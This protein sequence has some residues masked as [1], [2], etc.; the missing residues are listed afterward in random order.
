MYNLIEFFFDII[1]LGFFIATANMLAGKSWKHIDMKVLLGFILVNDIYWAFFDLNGSALMIATTYVIKNVLIVITISQV[2]KLDVLWSASLALI[3]ALLPSPL[4]LF[5]QM[6]MER[7]PYIL[8]HKDL[9]TLT[10]GI[11]V[12][13]GLMLTIVIFKRLLTPRIQKK[14]VKGIYKMR[15]ILS[16][17]LLLIS[18]SVFQS[19]LTVSDITIIDIV[20]NT[21]TSFIL[22]GIL[23]FVHINGKREKN[24]IEGQY[25]QIKEQQEK[26]YE[27]YENGMLVKHDYANILLSLK[28]AVDSENL[29][30]VS[31]QLDKIEASIKIG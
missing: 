28:Y 22:M 12:T 16:G 24:I 26:V 21:L 5:P 2:C 11:F 17:I 14:I 10:Y 18:I 6:I 20:I 8:K 23:A 30:E 1:H 9:Q 13:I 31:E 7:F 19:L 4:L 27:Y 15:F 25:N 3:V 29:K